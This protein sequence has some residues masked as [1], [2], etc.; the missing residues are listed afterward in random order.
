M[1]AHVGRDRATGSDRSGAVAAVSS[2]TWV[3]RHAGIGANQ[4]A[5]PTALGTLLP[6]CLD[7][8]LAPS[9]LDAMARY[10]GGPVIHKATTGPRLHSGMTEQERKSEILSTLGCIK[11]IRRT[12]DSSELR[13]VKQ[14]RLAG[15][16]WAE[17]AVTVGISRQAAWEKW[18]ELDEEAWQLAT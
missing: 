1:A 7:A 16:S 5:A 13:A 17:I 8:P 10:S 11:Q 15:V 9:Y 4:R 12:M 2:G 18:H 3:A 14:A 6:S